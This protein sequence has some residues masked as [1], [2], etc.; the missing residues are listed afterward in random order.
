MTALRGSGLQLPKR[1]DELGFSFPQ[2]ALQ[3]A[4]GDTKIRSRRLLLADRPEV[5]SIQ[6]VVQHPQKPLEVVVLGEC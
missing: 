3:G 5:D 1:L 4:L 2:P 6:H